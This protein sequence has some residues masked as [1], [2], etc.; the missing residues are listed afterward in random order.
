MGPWTLG[1]ES[2]AFLITKA[3]AGVVFGARTLNLE[4]MD[5]RRGSSLIGD[6]GLHLGRSGTTLLWPR[7][8]KYPTCAISDSKNHT[9]NG[10]LGPKT[11]NIGYLDPLG[12]FCKQSAPRGCLRRVRDNF[13]SQRHKVSLGYSGSTWA[14][15]ISRWVGAPDNDQQES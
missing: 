7:R 4:H 13:P 2:L 10:I 11:L 5:P 12:G 1:F 3:F 14:K 9:L 15:K 8:S 6:R